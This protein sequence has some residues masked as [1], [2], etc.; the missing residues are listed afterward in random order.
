MHGDN[1]DVGQIWGDF[2]V[3]QEEAGLAI[4]FHSLSIL[5][6]DKMVIKSN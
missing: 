2:V 3:I 6:S 4:T 5:S 1:S